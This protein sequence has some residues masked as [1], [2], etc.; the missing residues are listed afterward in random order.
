[1]RIRRRRPRGE[2]GVTSLETAILFPAVLL[3]LLT[4]MQVALL[5]FA[6]AAALAAAYAGATSGASYQSSPAA[7]AAAAEDFARSQAG[8]MLAGAHADPSGSSATTVRITVTGSALSLVPGLNLTVTQS[9]QEPIEE[10][11]N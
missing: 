5:Y 7:G 8:D 9:A 4:I 11:T 6:R 1:M 3:L 10:F 2:D